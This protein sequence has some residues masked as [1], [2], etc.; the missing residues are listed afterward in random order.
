MPH[1]ECGAFDHSATSPG[2]MA[3]DS[4][5]AVGAS[6]RR[7]WR[8]RQ[9]TESR[10]PRAPGEAKRSHKMEHLRVSANGAAFHVARTG[11]GQPLLLLHGWPEF[12][13]TWEGVMARLADRFTLYAP[14]LRAFTDNFANPGNLAGGFAHDRGAHA[15]RIRMMKGEARALPPITVPTC[16]RWAE[17]DPLFPYAWTDRL[18][19]TF[20]NLDLKMFPGVGHFPHREDPDRASDEIAAFFERIDWN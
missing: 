8:A 16:I 17:H 10:F 7:G 20:T 4:S 11:Q 9:G 3:G 15:G 5:P 18:S 1:F 6:S 14:D 2:A 12:W 19:E 13:L